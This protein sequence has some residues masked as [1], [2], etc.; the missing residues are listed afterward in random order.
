MRDEWKYIPGTQDGWVNRDGDVQQGGSLLEPYRHPDNGYRVVDLLVDTNMYDYEN[1][2]WQ[3]GQERV[4]V[5]QLVKE[6]FF[7]NWPVGRDAHLIFVDD[8]KWNCSVENIRVWSDR[9]GRIIEVRE[10]NW[11]YTFD[12]RMRGQVE[13]VETGQIYAGPSE[14]AKAVGGTRSGVSLVLSGKLETHRRHHFRW[15]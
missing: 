4:Y 5:W 8:D 11:G 9:L 1:G 14:A 15:V 3:R 2:G 13:I 7:F 6:A 10:D 12:R